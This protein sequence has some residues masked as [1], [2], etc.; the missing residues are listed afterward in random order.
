MTLR[1][2]VPVS[3]VGVDESFLR[4][5]DIPQ[6]SPLDARVALQGFLPSF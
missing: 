5:M 6:A 3:S 4:A 1:A 2:T